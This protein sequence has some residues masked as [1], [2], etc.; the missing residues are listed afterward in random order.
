MAVGT[1]GLPWFVGL[2]GG[3]AILT[4]PTGGYLAGFVLAAMAV[5]YA[6]RTFAWA[7][8]LTGL[9]LVLLAAN[10]VLIHGLGLIVFFLH[11]GIAE[12]IKL[13]LIGAIPF[14]DEQVCRPAIAEPIRLLWMG[15]SPFILGALTEVLAAVMIAWPFLQQPAP[16][17][18]S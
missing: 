5:G 8:T 17:A 13:L 12:P 10:F 18:K 15:I 6:V 3:L 7:R 1:A 4:G 16:G 11:I 9:A 2:G 14:I